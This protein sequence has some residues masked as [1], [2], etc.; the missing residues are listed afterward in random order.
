MCETMRNLNERMDFRSRPL[1]LPAGTELRGEISRR[2]S[3]EPGDGG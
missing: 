1:P 3:P 2:S